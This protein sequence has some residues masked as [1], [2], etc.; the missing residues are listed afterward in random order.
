MG[1]NLLSIFNV[2]FFFFSVL[3]YL[4]IVHDAVVPVMD[5]QT[6][7]MSDNEIEE[8]LE[9]AEHQEMCDSNPFYKYWTTSPQYH[10]MRLFPRKMSNHQHN[11][12]SLGQ[13]L[14]GFFEFWGRF[15]Y[16]RYQVSLHTRGLTKKQEW[17]YKQKGKG[18]LTFVIQDP[19][20]TAHNVA[21]NV[22]V[23]TAELLINEFKRAQLLLMYGAR[24][25]EDVCRPSEGPESRGHGNVWSGDMVRSQIMQF[26]TESNLKGTTRKYVDEYIVSK[27]AFSEVRITDSDLFDYTKCLQSMKENGLSQSG[28]GSNARSRRREKRQATKHYKR[29][30]KNTM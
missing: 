28:R 2:L 23:R 7:K 13:L 25:K 18:Q 29:R 3:K 30:R 6:L 20:D 1:F 24:W 14:F 19:V 27:F 22:R 8:K 11:K 17:I 10:A 12:Q 15:D 4:Q 9:S 21:K 26:R 5:Y 16:E